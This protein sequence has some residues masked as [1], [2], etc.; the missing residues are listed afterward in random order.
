VKQS[1]LL[2]ALVNALGEALL[3]R[4]LARLEPTDELA[5]PIDTARFLNWA[6]GPEGP[7]AARFVGPVAQSAFSSR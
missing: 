1:E 4:R 2:D 5:L 3:D 7:A 6:E